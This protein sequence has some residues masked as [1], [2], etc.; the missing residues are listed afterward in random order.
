M[1]YSTGD[2]IEISRRW[3]L[4]R[5]LK[6]RMF[7][8]LTLSHTVIAGSQ[9]RVYWPTGEYSRPCF[10]LRKGTAGRVPEVGHLRRRVQWQLTIVTAGI[11]TGETAGKEQLE[12]WMERIVREVHNRPIP[13]YD[14]SVETPNRVLDYD[15]TCLYEGDS[16]EPGER[17]KPKDRNLGQISFSVTV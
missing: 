15:F 10:I 2:Y 16:R 8:T 1:A 6:E 11:T 3:S 9:F 7:P 14:Y 13:F 12:V 5:Y 4:L 17:V